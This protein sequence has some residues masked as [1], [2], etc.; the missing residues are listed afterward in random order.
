MTFR[1]WSCYKDT[2]MTFRGDSC[3]RQACSVLDAHQLRQ[4]GHFA[5]IV[6]AGAAAAAATAALDCCP[7]PPCASTN[8][9]GLELWCT[10]AGKLPY[11]FKPPDPTI[12]ITSVA[13]GNIPIKSF[14]SS[15][16]PSEFFFG[17]HN[18]LLDGVCR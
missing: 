13:S 8:E 5:C 4:C 17:E 14:K 18:V 6:G 1:R 7:A 11:E 3:F 16:A 15:S 12:S 10:L 9:L 2:L